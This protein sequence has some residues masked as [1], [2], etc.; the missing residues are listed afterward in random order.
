M[1]EGVLPLAV[2]IDEDG[3]G[4][5]ARCERLGDHAWR[6]ETPER[7]LEALARDI[8]GILER[9]KARV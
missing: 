4:F 2:S 8:L 5:F 6:G 7:A 3:D 9:Y 1:P